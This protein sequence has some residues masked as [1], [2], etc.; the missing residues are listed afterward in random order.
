LSDAVDPAQLTAENLPQY[1][2]PLRRAIDDLPSCDLSSEEVARLGHGLAIEKN[3]SLSKAAECAGIG[4]DGELRS[5]L[6]PRGD[7]RW[8]PSLNFAG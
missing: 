3:I 7:N 5:I 6:A 2:L 1:L 8:G 4:P